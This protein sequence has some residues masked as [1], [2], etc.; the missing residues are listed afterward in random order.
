LIFL[1]G[2]YALRGYIPFNPFL[3]GAN[4]E[5]NLLVSLEERVGENPRFF[6]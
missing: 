3:I 6:L 4:L 2:L 5:V 1:I